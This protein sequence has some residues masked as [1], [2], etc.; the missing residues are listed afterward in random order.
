MPFFGRGAGLRVRRRCQAVACDIGGTGSL[1]ARALRF[2]EKVVLRKRKEPHCWGS[3]GAMGLGVR[4]GHAT[5]FTRLHRV[6]AVAGFSP[7]LLES[8][9]V[10]G[11]TRSRW[12]PG[13]VA[14]GSWLRRTPNPSG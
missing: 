12:A 13:C 1:Q 8:L 5:G 14:L 11:F 9:V 10:T 4:S 6:L 7:T 2:V 3:E